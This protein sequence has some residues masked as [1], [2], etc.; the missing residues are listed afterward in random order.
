MYASIEECI[1]RAGYKPLTNGDRIRAM[2]DEELAK[3]FDAM[4]SYCA[5]GSSPSPCICS[6][7]ECINCWI[8]WL[9]QPAKEET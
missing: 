7:S 6:L 8:N 4:A 1:D 5:P 3:E 9:K 2:T